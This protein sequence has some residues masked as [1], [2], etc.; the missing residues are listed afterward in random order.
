MHAQVARLAIAELARITPAAGM[1]AG[2][3]IAP[4]RRPD[5]HFPIERRRRRARCRKS[6]SAAVIA[7]DI[8][9]P[10]FPKLPALNVAIARFEDMRGAAPLETHLHS[11]L[12][13]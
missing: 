10:D 8:D 5:I 4:G 2:V 7:V 9:I 3:I 13:F 11:A 6:S 1:D 12:V